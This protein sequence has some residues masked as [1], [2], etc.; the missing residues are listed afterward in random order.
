MLPARGTRCDFRL[1]RVLTGSH[2]AGGAKRSW[3]HLRAAATVSAALWLVA[4]AWA[5]A[6]D[7]VAR[8]AQAYPQLFPAA[9][10]A[11]AAVAGDAGARLAAMSPELAALGFRHDDVILAVDGRP[12]GAPVWDPAVPAA[13][14]AVFTVWRRLPGER[15]V[16]Q[17]A[18]L[19]R[20][21]VDEFVGFAAE[22]RTP[23]RFA[24][25]LANQRTLVRDG[26]G[27]VLV[28]APEHEEAWLRLAIP[29]PEASEAAL[30][31][32]ADAVRRR[33]RLPLAAGGELA[34]AKAALGRN[35]FLEAQERARRA[36]V[37]A[38]LDPASRGDRSRL[39]PIL[40][41]YVDARERAHRQRELLLQPP[42][43]LAFVLE[44][45]IGRIQPFLPQKTLLTVENSTSW[46]FALGA[47]WRPPL[48][49]VP[50]LRDLLLL[51]EYGQA[52]NTFRSPPDP[53]RVFF[54]GTDVLSTT[55]QQI[56]LELLYR[57][58]VPTRLRPHLRGGV[59]VFPFSGRVT[60]DGLEC[61]QLD[62]IEP[63]WL[64]GAG[65]DVLQWRATGLRASIV[66]TY[67]VVH[68][69]IPYGDA[70][71]LDLCR[72]TNPEILAPD[73]YEFD[74]DGWQVG[75]QL[76]YEL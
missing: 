35:R 28:P 55:L 62:D 53:E 32:L 6:E 10:L 24:L 7:A 72:N 42:A 9:A 29:L 17:P 22:E 31:E 51:A 65:F 60:R 48:E 2:A 23:M 49:G 16:V 56:S 74:M 54:P 20:H 64:V 5:L 21:V 43:P 3:S 67:R 59:G 1:E 69:R 37:E 25:M 57:P 19:A 70:P 39:D 14:G 12:L 52:R 18:V 76:A 61:T 33:T 11:G 44:G 63:G 75:L 30:R 50:V 26:A 36:A 68:F 34:A 8:L 47:R 66:G 38:V 46:A 45:Q 41:V 4:P 71:L 58:R 13:A 73:V 15:P 40:A 27:V